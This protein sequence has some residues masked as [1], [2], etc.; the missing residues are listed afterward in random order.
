MEQIEIW[1]LTSL[2]L[3]GIGLLFLY[4]VG[5]HPGD[6]DKTKSKTKY[7]TDIDNPNRASNAQANANVLEV[8]DYNGVKILHESGIWT[9]ND[10]GSVKVFGDWI[11]VPP[12]YQKMV[13]ELDNRSIGN[14]KKPDYFLEILNGFYY[15]SMP[16]GKKKK[17]S[18]FADIPPDIR[19][20]LGK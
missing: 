20:F 8:F 2:I 19:K 7:N 17:Y 13:K 6:K 10:A 5:S 1:I 18:T 3:A 15:V 11:R 12:K 4:F 9:V 16:G 14:E